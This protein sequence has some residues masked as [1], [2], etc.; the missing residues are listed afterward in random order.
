[1][2][3]LGH[4]CLCCERDKVQGHNQSP[5]DTFPSSEAWL[6]HVHLNVAGPLP[7]SN[8]YTHLLPLLN[9]YDERKNNFHDGLHALLMQ[10]DK[11]IALGDFNVPNPD[12]RRYL[13]RYDRSLP[14]RWLQS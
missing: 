7:P 6:N 9:S 5:P 3:K 8:G 11:L 14:I 4:G 12:R 10:A 1:M 2:P 13:E